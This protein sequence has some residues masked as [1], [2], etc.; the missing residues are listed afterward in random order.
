MGENNNYRGLT[1]LSAITKILK[2]IVERRFRQEVEP[3]LPELQSGFF[4]IKMH[5]M[6][7]DVFTVKKITSRR[8]ARKQTAYVVFIDMGEAFNSFPSVKIW[9]YLEKRKKK[10]RSN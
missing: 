6:H 9:E 2:K 5:K 7:K 1:L 8:I 10:E 3:T 4:Q